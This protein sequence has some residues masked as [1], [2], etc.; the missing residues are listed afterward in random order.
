MRRSKSVTA[1]KIEANRR[2][3]KH[4][5]GPRTER[6]K[7][8]AKFNAVTL[9]LFAKHV[10]IPICDGYEAERDFQF[11]I[12]GLHADFQPV[13]MYE[14]WLV[15]KVAECMWRLRR[16][17]IRELFELFLEEQVA[18]RTRV[19]GSL[20]YSQNANN[21]RRRNLSLRF[22]PNLRVGDLSSRVLR[23]LA[24]T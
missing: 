12:D 1:K 14:E 7:L 3:G 9:G 19:E 4:S 23:S 22:R 2:N 18:S 15:L 20:T 11:L 16:A 24:H 6:G 13:G 17:T 8:A 10:V 21:L 5:T